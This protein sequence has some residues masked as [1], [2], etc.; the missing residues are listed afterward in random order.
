VVGNN[1]CRMLNQGCCRRPNVPVGIMDSTSMRLTCARVHLRY[2]AAPNLPNSHRSA[3]D[4]M[5]IGPKAGSCGT[6][7]YRR[8]AVFIPDIL[9]DPYIPL[10]SRRKDESALWRHK[11]LPS[12]LDAG[13]SP[14]CALNRVSPLLPGLQANNVQVWGIL[15]ETH[16]VPLRTGSL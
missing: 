5:A 16:Q 2:A 6:A 3:T 14:V 4:G 1:L 12:I 8:E 9:C 7:V 11:E 15:R 13:S 10:R